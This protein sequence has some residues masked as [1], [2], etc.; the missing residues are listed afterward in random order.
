VKYIGCVTLNLFSCFLGS[1]AGGCS[2]M[3]TEA[4]VFKGRAWFR[5]MKMDF[6]AITDQLKI[7]KNF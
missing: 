6:L 2:R 1:R 4:V 7:V 5:A 3:L